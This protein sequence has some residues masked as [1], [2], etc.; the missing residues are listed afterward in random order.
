M[1]AL[2]ARRGRRADHWSAGIARESEEI[3][4]LWKGSGG[5]LGEVTPSAEGKDKKEA[6]SGTR[7]GRSAREP[8]GIHDDT[9]QP[10]QLG[11]LKH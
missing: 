5:R 1:I 9:Q 6:V 8:A 11:E 4:K 7:E 2:R 3:K 10:T